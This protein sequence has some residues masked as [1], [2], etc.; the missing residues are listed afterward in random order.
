MS[1]PPSP[2]CESLDAYSTDYRP[3]HAFR[4]NLDTVAD[5]DYDCL[6]IEATLE[7]NVAGLIC[8]ATLEMSSARGG[9][10]RVVDHTYW[11]NRQQSVN[12][13]CAELVAL[14]FPAQTWGSG[15]GKTPLS[16]AI[17]AV[18]PQLRGARF[19]AT[20]SSRVVASKTPHQPSAT[21]H[22]LR[23]HGRLGASVMGQVAPPMPPLGRSLEE[24][25]F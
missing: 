6:V 18:V 9:P 2:G 11:L 13:F 22:D 16:Q 21:Y 10:A 8:R 4:A 25:P 3:E 17:P 7:N 23:I 24:I 19:R 14:G 20:K 15:T 1:F 12:A 5:G